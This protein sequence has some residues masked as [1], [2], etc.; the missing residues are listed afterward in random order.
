MGDIQ[1]L[2]YFNGVRWVHDYQ[3]ACIDKLER[4]VRQDPF[5][6]TESPFHLSKS[7]ISTP[8]RDS[9]PSLLSPHMKGLRNRTMSIDSA[10]DPQHFSRYFQVICYVPYAATHNLSAA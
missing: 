9:T 3:D 1:A 6:R 5:L 4:F 8:R 2:C 10:S 7:G